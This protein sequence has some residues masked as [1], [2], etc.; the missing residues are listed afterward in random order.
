[1]IVFDTGG[2]GTDAGTGFMLRWFAGPC[3]SPNEQ[4]VMGQSCGGPVAR[5][6]VGVASPGPYCLIVADD[7]SVP[8][9]HVG[10]RAFPLSVVT[11]PTCLQ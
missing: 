7:A 9:A 11:P 4:G 1:M 10:L 5:I 8:A 6:L 2:Q 3:P